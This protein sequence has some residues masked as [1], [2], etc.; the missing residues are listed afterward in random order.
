[1]R[2]GSQANATK[3]KEEYHK[4]RAA[5]SKQHWIMQCQVSTLPKT[6]SE[7]IEQLNVDTRSEWRAKHQKTAQW[8]KMVLNVGVKYP[9]GA[10][11]WVGIWPPILKQALK[12]RL[13]KCNPTYV[14]AFNKHIIKS[15]QK[16]VKDTGGG[17]ISTMEDTIK[18]L[19][20]QKAL[21]Q[22]QPKMELFWKT[23]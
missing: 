20:E 10:D 2:I 19:E 13:G 5:R 7:Y 1:M 23:P 16:S 21:Y 18:Q 6:R 14:N 11:A 22:D 15:A 17:R 9:K 4:M 8:M 3:T 12:S